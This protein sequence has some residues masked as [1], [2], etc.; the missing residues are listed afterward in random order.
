MSSTF[1][2]VPGYKRDL[3]SHLRQTANVRFAFM[4]TQMRIV[5]I[6]AVLLNAKPLNFTVET[7]NSA[8]QM[9]NKHFHVVTSVL[10]CLP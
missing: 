9:K 4:S 5:A 1:L 10:C 3:E 7:E 2:R 8:R 6:L